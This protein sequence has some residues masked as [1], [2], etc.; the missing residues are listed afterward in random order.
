MRADG[1]LVPSKDKKVRGKVI[2]AFKSKKSNKERKAINDAEKLIN[3]F[4]DEGKDR[5]LD[6]LDKAISSTSSNGRAFDAT[7]GI[8]M[9]AVNSSLK[10]VRASYKAGKTIV[11]AIQDSL[12]QLKKQGYTPNEAKYKKYV[13]DALSKETTP[14]KQKSA[15]EEFREGKMTTTKPVKIYKGIGGKKDIRGQRIN[16]HKGVKGI[17]SAVDKNLAEEYGREEGVAEID[18]PAGVTVEVVEVDTKGLDA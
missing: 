14:K 16:A 12:K 15:V 6:F 1:K 5:I 10:I 13:V 11:E 3:E 2:G 4:K 17:F 7:I 8:P 18:L 9:F